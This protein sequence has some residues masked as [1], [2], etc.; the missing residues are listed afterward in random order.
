MG[1]FLDINNNE[2]LR[3]KN[4]AQINA[5]NGKTG[6][7]YAGV[8]LSQLAPSIFMGVLNKIESSQDGKGG[9]DSKNLSVDED[10]KSYERKLN[11]A[12]N[13]IGAENA[14]DINEAITRAQNERDTKVKAAQT[15][16]DAYKNGTDTY[17]TQI[18]DLEKQLTNSNIT[19]EEKTKINNDIE[20]LENKK[21]KALEKAE[22]NLEKV[23]K[24]ENAKVDTVC[25]N[26]SYAF[27]YLEILASMKSI[28]DSQEVTVEEQNEALNEIVTHRNL[29]NRNNESLEI[30]KYAALR[31]KELAESNPDNKTLQSGYRIIEQQVDDILNGKNLDNY[32]TIVGRKTVAEVKEFCKNGGKIIG[33]NYYKDEDIKKSLQ[34]LNNTTFGI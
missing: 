7:S 14:D 12:L 11:K 1:Y 28:D 21:N 33:N 5:A 18:A 20:K 30:K 8:I 15:D 34:K 22:K 3:A 29:I 23:V 25:E 32:K 27:S 17:S 24:A 19:D 2:D 31:I 6:H 26:A 4:T 10:R 13:K 9:S 16:V